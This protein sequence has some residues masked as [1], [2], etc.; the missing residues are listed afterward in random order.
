MN[1]NSLAAL[2]RT[3]WKPGQSGNPSGSPEKRLTTLMAMLQM[4]EAFLRPH[5]DH[6]G[7]TYWQV[8]CEDLAAD[9][10]AGNRYAREVVAK[11]KFPQPRGPGFMLNQQINTDGGNGR[12]RIMEGLNA[13]LAQRAAQFTLEAEPT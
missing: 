9:W 2:K 4:D 8:G 13:L 6:P 5:P 1:P 10:A 7:K 11:I 3:Q 12:G